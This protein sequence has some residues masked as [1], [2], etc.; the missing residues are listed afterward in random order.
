MVGQRRLEGRTAIV[1][2]GGADGPARHG[3]QLP[4][5][6]GRAIALRLAA[7]GAR[8]TVTDIDLDRAQETVDALE[9]EGI[10]IRADLADAAA[11]RAAIGRSVEHLGPPDVVVANA[12][13][14]S[15]TPLRAQTVED[16][17]RG[18]AVNVR[19]HWVSAQAALEHMLPRGRGSFVFVGSTA[20]VLSSGSDLA[21]EASKA[22]QLAVMRHIAVRY[23]DRGVRSNAVVLGVIDSTMVRRV[24]G[25]GTD[26]TAARDRIC[27][28]RRQGTPEEVAAAAAFLASDDAGFVNG[29]S[30]VVDGG[31]TASWPT[32]PPVAVMQEVD[33]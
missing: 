33:R 18:V 9:S 30:L 16:F 19:G 1:L 27:P 8:V 3:E 12:A 23:A 7:E 4:I 32:P 17:D 29:H 24:F 13:I 26:R 6:N 15:R 22:A 21:Y 31:V 20:G 28:M 2:G 10:A 14:G 25:D 5:G 11:C